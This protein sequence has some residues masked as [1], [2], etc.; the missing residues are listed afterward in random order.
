MQF[1]S[2]L[3]EK[4]ANLQQTRLKNSGEEAKRELETLTATE[5]M[6]S[7]GISVNRSSIPLHGL[8]RMKQIFISFEISEP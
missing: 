3:P 6:T 5:L 8:H 4:T 1:A 2:E 7:N